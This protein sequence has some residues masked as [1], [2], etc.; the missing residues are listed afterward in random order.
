CGLRLRDFGCEPDV[1]NR[2]TAGLCGSPGPH[3]HGGQRR[4]A[5]V[6][7]QAGSVAGGQRGMSA[8]PLLELRN[9]GRSFRTPDGRDLVVLRDVNLAVNEGEFVSLVGASGCGKSTL[10][11]IIHG[12]IPLTTG[13]IR[14]H[15]Q[16]VQGPGRDRAMVFQQDSLLPWRTV[17]DNVA[18]GLLLAK[19]P[20][21]EAYHR[22]QQ[23]VDMVGLRGF[24]H[25]YPHQIS[26]GMRQRT[27]VAR[28]LAVNPKVLLMDEPFAALDAQTREV[29][30]RELLRIWQT[31]KKTVLFVTHQID[32]AVFL[33][34]RVIVL[35]ARPGTVRAD[36]RIDLPQPRELTIKRSARFAE[37][38]DEIWAL[39]ERDVVAAMSVTK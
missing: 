8:Q 13:E 12:L 3:R 14:V 11:R 10:L 22:A 7:T 27:N 26:G 5:S 15:G 16:V 38:V 19:V 29:M 1:P 32:E 9:A 33:S 37:L 28:A 6:G 21:D 36:I 4:L 39:V 24:E 30:Q 17:I 34:D 20:K 18:Y 31:E 25:Y 2:Q 35:G 23:F